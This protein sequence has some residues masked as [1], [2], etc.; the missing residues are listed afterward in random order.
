MG[1]P[2]FGETRE[3]K[4]K[5]TELTVKHLQIH[6]LPVIIQT[7]HSIATQYAATPNQAGR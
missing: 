5:C 2:A 1:F 6:L 4:E 3:R 7:F